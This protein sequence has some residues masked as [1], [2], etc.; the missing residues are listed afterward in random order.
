MREA[1]RFSAMNKNSFVSLT[2]ATALLAV[3]FALPVD[4]LARGRSTTVYGA[5]GGTFQ[6]QVN[7]TPGNFSASGSA[8][9]ADGRS[10]S[11]SFTTQ[12]TDTGRTTGGRVTGFN[13]KTGTYDSTRT[14]TD[15]GYTRQVNVAGPNGGTGSKKVDVSRQNGTVT[16]TV[17]ATHTPAP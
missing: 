5:R 2:S 17:A 12:R 9:L 7:H 10:A 11:R 13:G 3:A 8:R 14:R 16:R 4:V 6:R 15:T 1:K